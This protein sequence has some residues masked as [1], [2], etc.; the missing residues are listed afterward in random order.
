MGQVYS[1]NTLGGNWSVPD[2]TQNLRSVSQPMFRL[3]SF[4][5]A[6]EAQGL[7]GGDTWLFDKAG[8][9]QT[10]GGTL[11]ETSTIPETDFITNQGTGVVTE[12]GNAIGYTFKVNAMG[13]FSVPSNVEQRLRD[14]MVKVIESAAGDAYATTDYTAVCNGTATVDILTSGTATATAAVNGNARNHRTIINDMKTKLIPKYDGSNYVCV[15]S[16]NYLAGFHEDTASAGFVPISQYTDAHAAA[17]HSG[18]VG[19]FYG[20]RFVEETGYL[21]NTL[22]ASNDI[23]QAFYFGADNVYEAISVPEEIRV[24][25]SNDYGRDLGLAWYAILGFK[26]VWDY[27]V[28][29]E[30]HVLFV[31][32]AS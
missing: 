13:Q 31:T 17:L 25:N 6:H 11:V 28:D 24:K 16:I 12:Y 23:G 5:D 26:L 30:Q 32:S 20:C 4:I 8:N 7:G 9:V 1:V 21:S 10:Q 14:D 27:T 19:S 29:G 3:R 15:G 2:L 22:G 18:E